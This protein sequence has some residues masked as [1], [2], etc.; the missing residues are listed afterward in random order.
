M[1]T[2][3]TLDF[4]MQV[5]ID[6]GSGW[7]NA[8]AT[9]PGGKE[10]REI[11]F[12][13]RVARAPD[14]WQEHFGAA[15]SRVV[16]IKD[17]DW[18]IGAAVRTFGAQQEDTLQ[19]EWALSEG[20]LAL[21]YSALADLAPGAGR[22]VRVAV[23]TGL[24]QA[25][26][27]DQERAVVERLLG[28]HRCEV[29][30]SVYQFHVE[31]CFV[32]PQATAALLYQAKLDPDMEGDCG[33]I[34]IG[35]YTTG[36]AVIDMESMSLIAPRSTGTRVGVANLLR[37]LGAFLRERHGVT[38]D[39]ARLMGALRERAVRVRGES[40]DLSGAIAQISVQE[41]KPILEFVQAAWGGAADLDVYLA[42]GGAELFAEAIR[43]VVPHAKIILDPQW[44]VARGLGVW[45][46]EM[47]EALKEVR[48]AV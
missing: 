48:E 41:A 2:T 30:G 5:A 34:D 39:D 45:L 36:L 31:Q 12:A 38:L 15:Q 19:D 14:A 43:T 26:Y 11:L 32:A 40:V 21:F 18:L 28:E 7:T 9:F 37:A 16:R 46:D 8:R 27:K 23:A 35:T 13:S 29:N 4:D 25:R 10:P 33:C 42:G 24:P 3:H 6:I 20:W 1:Q 44:A 47:L 22:S 17:A